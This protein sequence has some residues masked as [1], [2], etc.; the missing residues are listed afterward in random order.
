MKMVYKKIIAL[1]LCLVMV[2]SVAACGKT[3]KDKSGSVSTTEKTEISYGEVWSAPSTV[4]VQQYDMDYAQKGEAALSYD[5]VKNEYESQQLYIS[6]KKNVERFELQSA[7]LKCGNNVLSSDNVDIYMQN[8]VHYNEGALNGDV[9]D[10]LIPMDA[11]DEYKENTIE[12]DANGALWITIYVPKETVAGLYEGTFHLIVEGEDGK[13]EMAIPVSVNVYDYTLTDDVN[14]QT[15]FSWRF[16]RVATG[17]LDGSIEMMEYYY[18][19][20]QDYRIS[21][22]VLPIEGASGDEF[23]ASV[24]KYYDDIT[25]YNLLPAPGEIETKFLSQPDVIK[26][27]ILA[28]AAASTSE[29]NL[30]DKVMC[31][32]IDEPD[33]DDESQRLNYIK[34]FK[35]IKALFQS[36]VDAIKAD[37]SGKY[38]EFK[39]IKNWEASILDI[40]C[41][42]PIGGGCYWLLENID[43]PEAKEVL[44]VMNCICPQFKFT[45]EA[46][47]ETWK[48]VC[49]EYDIE[50]WW[51]GCTSPKPPAATYHISDDNLLN[52]RTISWLQ[53]KEDIVGNLYWDAAAYVDDENGTRGQFTNVYEFPYR[54]LTK[55]WPAGDGFLVYPGAAYGIYGPLPSTR[56]MSIRDGMEEYEILRELTDELEANKASFGKDFNVDNVMNRFYESLGDSTN[57]AADGANGLNFTELRKE[58]IESIVG[59]DAGATFMIEDVDIVDTEAI[60]TYFVQAGSTVSVNGEQQQAVSGNKFEFRLDLTKETSI[61]VKV[62]N[63][64]GK[65][66]EFTRFISKLSYKMN[67]LSDASVMDKITVS[68]GSKAEFVSNKTYSTDGTSVHFNVNGVITGNE[69]I[70]ATFVPSILLGTALFDDV[71]LKDVDEVT[72]DVYNPGEE[73]EVIL[74]LYSGVSYTELGTYTIA[75]GRTIISLKLNQITAAELEGADSIAFEFANEKDGKALKYELYVDSII[76]RK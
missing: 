76:G 45:S 19:F 28:L 24:L 5:V 60:I 71:Q 36:C 73:Y 23:V 6:A 22:Q 75:N 16:N 53:C 25:T 26:E 12:A 69:L 38:D 8:Y 1:V 21:L 59:L 18:E 4:K 9:T 52:S 35:K 11:A 41:I 61:H 30:F 42:T 68:D 48:R 51:Y 57:M 66:V 54:S 64:E 65:A 37:T 40:R 55:K 62:T 14:A 15:L 72:M 67:A 47:L 10:A 70:D 56:L 3:N 49:E 2:A 46:D 43:T 33:F 13:E 7:D 74:K 31:Y 20:F 58:L 50:L 63:S 39:K 44:E 17:E 29:K 27:Q 32:P 34:E